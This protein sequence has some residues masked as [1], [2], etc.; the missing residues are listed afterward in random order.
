FFILFLFLF[1]FI[2]VFNL[3][4]G[5]VSMVFCIFFFFLLCVVLRFL[6]SFPTRRSSDLQSDCDSRFPG[7]TPCTYYHYFTSYHIA[8]PPL[9]FEKMM[10]IILDGGWRLLF[11][12][13]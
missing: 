6:L 9:L 8:M 1:T 13:Q 7:I 2:S 4:F 11:L 3:S 5:S 12:S 10:Q